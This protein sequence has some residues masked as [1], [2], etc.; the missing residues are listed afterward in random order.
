MKSKTTM[1]KNIFQ[2]KEK[3]EKNQPELKEKYSQYLKDKKNYETVKKS[4]F[5]KESKSEHIYGISFK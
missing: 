1:N 2:M 5:Y 4:P 3:L